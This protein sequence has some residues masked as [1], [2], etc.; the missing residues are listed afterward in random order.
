[1]DDE[2]GDD[3]DEMEQ[4]SDDFTGQVADSDNPVSEKDEGIVHHKRGSQ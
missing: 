4:L 2:Y 3:D 1:M